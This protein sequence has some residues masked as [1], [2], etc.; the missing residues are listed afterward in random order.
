[1]R[2]PNKSESLS[3]AWKVHIQDWQTTEQSQSAYCKSHDL[4]YHCFIRM[5]FRGLGVLVEQGLEHNPFDGGLYVFTNRQ[6]NKIK[7][8]Y[9]GDN[10]FVLYYKSLAEEKFSWPSQCDELIVV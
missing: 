3:T 9:W 8:L 7:C 1:M 6:H 10:G 5:G 4:N 2:E